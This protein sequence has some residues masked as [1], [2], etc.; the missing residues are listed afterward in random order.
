M[1]KTRPR[2]YLTR[3]SITADEFNSVALLLPV[4][5]A[6]GTFIGGFVAVMG[7]VFVADLLDL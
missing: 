2:D 5:I 7:L 1:I 6:T 4:Q 3:E